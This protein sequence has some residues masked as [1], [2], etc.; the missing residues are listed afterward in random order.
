MN[1]LA[2]LI[3]LVTIAGPLAAVA[4][5]AGDDSAVP[6]PVVD[7][8]AVDATR[9]DGG[10][11]DAALDAA[12]TSRAFARIAQWSTNGH[13]IDLCLAPAG[14][15]AFGGPFLSSAFTAPPDGGS[16]GVPF[17]WASAYLALPPG[18]FDVR[19]VLAGATNCSAGL[20]ADFHDAGLTANSVWTFAAFA[21]PDGGA[22]SVVAFR[23]DTSAPPGGVA[24]RFVN[25][26]PH[27][28]G[29]AL[30]TD[31]QGPIF[32][33][34]S[35]ADASKPSDSANPGLVVDGNG[36]ATLA[37][38][39]GDTLR[40]STF[41]DASPTNVASTVGATIAGGAVVTVVLVPAHG[42]DGAAA[43]MLVECFDNAGTLGLLGDCIGPDGG[44]PPGM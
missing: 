44:A 34:V 11:S 7:A 24:M 43:D 13:P 27:G 15:N 9:A 22:G 42:L 20:G 3:G 36:Y 38:L 21:A 28:V 8:G 25:A 2:R 17:P 26:D 23:D 4:C 39:A 1:R 40:A 31:L 33:G 12:P 14:S 37:P 10:P 16:L 6:A 18:A 5:G 30:G 35:F 29:A 32:Q 19:L 41:T